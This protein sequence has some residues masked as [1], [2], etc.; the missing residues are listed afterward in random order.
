MPRRSSGAR[1]V[2]VTGGTSTPIEDL[3][4]GHRAH[5]RQLAGTPRPCKQRPR[6]AHEALERAATPADRSTSL[7]RPPARAD[8]PA[9]PDRWPPS[10]VRTR[11]PRGSQ[12]PL[13]GLPVVALVGRPNVGK[14]TLFNRI[15]GERSAI[16]EDRA[17]TTRDRLYADADWNGRRFV[18]VDT[19][20]LELDPD[21]PI[22]AQASRSRP[23]W[24]SPRPTSS[25]SWSTRRPARRPPTTRPPSSCARATAPVI[26][27]VNKADNEKRELEGAEFHAPRLGGDL[28][29]HRARTVAARATCSTRSSGPC[30]PRARPSSRARRARRRPRRGPRTIAAGRLEP[31]VVGDPEAGDADDSDGAEAP[32]L[33][34]VD[35]EAAKWDAAMAADADVP[36]AIAFVGRPNVGK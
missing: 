15:V 4:D 33:D 8:S 3:R 20:G 7:G 10:I 32:D 28:R 16:V 29:D 30:R 31:F 17:R 9:P 21:D 2:G 23:G 25:C 36:A 14:S 26:V 13:D 35:A 19:G 34:G 24:P 22:E 1:I 18:V 27:V 6:L 11:E 12:A 5:P